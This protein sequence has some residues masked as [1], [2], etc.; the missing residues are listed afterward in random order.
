MPKREKRDLYT[1]IK[2]AYPRKILFCSIASARRLLDEKGKGGG[3]MSLVLLWPKGR[4]RRKR[5]STKKKGWRGKDIFMLASAFMAKEKRK[6]K[7]KKN[8][9]PTYTEKKE[10]KKGKGR[11]GRVRCPPR[12]SD[13]RGIGRKKKKKKEEAFVPLSP[14][15]CSG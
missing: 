1:T 2:E 10:G 15:P 4:G 3:R 14:M 7:K 8:R 5:E 9:P 6:K 11:G 13:F 12:L